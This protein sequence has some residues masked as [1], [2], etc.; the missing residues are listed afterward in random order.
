[1][2]GIFKP[3]LHQ[4]RLP[5]EEIDKEY[6]VLRW[7]VFIGIF[8]G[9]AGYYLVRKNFSLAMPFLIEEQG[10]TKGQLGIALSAVSIAYGLS[11]FLMGSVSDRSNPRYF[12]MTGLLI[13]S[14]VMFLFGFADWATQSVASIFILLFINGWAQGMGWPACGRTMVH[15]YSGNERGQTV[16]FWNIAHNVG[17]G[18]IGPL[19]ILGMAWF[20][21]WHSAFYVPAVAATLIAVFIYF[22]MR[23]TPQSCGLPPIEEYRN[24]YPAQYSKSHEVELTAKQ[25]FMQFVLNNK[26]LWCIA[27]ANAF[28]YLIRYGVLDW[29]PTYLYEV[30]DFSFDKSSWAY[31]A[32]EW[33]GIPG[34]L[35][36]GW[37]SD[38][39]FKGRRAPAAILYMLLVLVAVVIYWLNPAGNPT[40]D[41][42][43]LMAIGFLI[44]GPVMLIGLFALELVPKKAAGTAAGLTGLF[45]Y[46]GGAVVANIALGYTVDHFGWDGGFV[47]LVGGCIGAILLIALTLKH[48]VAHESHQRE[49]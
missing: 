42:V 14:G 27:V 36:C 16:S 49:A 1:M 3:A 24:D 35:L 38:R 11:K 2:F 15:W 19:F 29:A 20:N 21:D 22:V 12:L 18:L 17:G 30:K 40:I 32:Y 44:Y 9:Y 10:F 13:S 34:T 25:I 41:I 48:E 26:L 8:V 28:V 31:F 47:L 33:A 5:K 37:I 4:P 46:L 43:A 39:W 45:G 7:Q 6:K 23:D